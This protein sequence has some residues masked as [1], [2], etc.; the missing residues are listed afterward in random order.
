L[1]VT[2]TLA[3][4]EHGIERRCRILEDHGQAASPQVRELPLVHLQDVFAMEQDL[5]LGDARQSRQDAQ[6]RFRRRGLAAA[7]LTDQPNLLTKA[8]S[9][10]DAI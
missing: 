1:S 5:A 10:V 9:E 3:D 8:D 4:G 7:G 6:H 2:L